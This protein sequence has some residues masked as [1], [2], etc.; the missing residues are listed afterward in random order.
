MFRRMKDKLIEIM[1]ENDNEP[2]GKNI[3]VFVIL[4]SVQ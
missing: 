2:N 3:K 4:K 1:N